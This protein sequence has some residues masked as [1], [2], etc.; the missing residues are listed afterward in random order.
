[1]N[2]QAL[3]DLVRTLTPAARKHLR[4]ILIRDDADRDAISSQLMRYRDQ[5]DRTGST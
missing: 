5:M 4:N 3:R 2:D 1:M